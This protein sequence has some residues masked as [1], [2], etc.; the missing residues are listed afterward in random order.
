MSGGAAA[1]CGS[2]KCVELDDLLRAAPAALDQGAPGAAPKSH[3]IHRPRAQPSIAA[4]GDGTDALLE[5]IARCGTAASGLTELDGD[6]PNGEG[7]S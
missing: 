4:T 6:L 7:R 1:S 2:C 3:I 5:G